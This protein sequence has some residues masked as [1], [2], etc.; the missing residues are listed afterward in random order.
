MA[1]RN[2]NPFSGFDRSNQQQKPVGL[3]KSLLT[4]D[5]K[6]QQ[7][8]EGWVVFDAKATAEAAAAKKDT[9]QLIGLPPS[10]AEEWRK[11]HSISVFGHDCPS[12][13]PDFKM[14]TMLPPFIQKKF[15]DRGFTAPTIIQA[16]SWPILFQNRDFVGIAKTGSGKTMA[17][18]VPAIAHI[19]VQ[20]QL[21]PGDGPIVV[22]LAPTRELAQQ[23]EEETKKILPTTMRCACIYGGSPK[24]PQIQ[25]L[26]DGVHI[27]VATP[28]RLIDMLEIKRTNLLRTTYVVLDEADRM[29][30]MGFE[31]QVRSIFG[32]VRPDRQTLMFSATWPKE[33]QS[34][35]A[36]FQKDFIRINV[37]STELLAN[38]DVT[39]EFIYT[40]E[41]GKYVELRKLMAKHRDT[42]VLVFCKTKKTADFLERQLRNVGFDIMAIH[43][44]KEQ[45]QREYILD[46]FRRE[47][48]L[49]VVA[50]DVAARGLDIKNLEVVINYDFPM[51]IDDYVHRIGRTGRAGA[52]GHSYTLISKKE[53]QITPPVL[54]QLLSIIQKAG[55]E[56][57]EFLSE[58]AN[59]RQQYSAV[60]RPRDSHPARGAPAMRYNHGNAPSFDPASGQRAN[61]LSGQQHLLAQP[62][63]AANHFGGGAQQ[64]GNRAYTRF[65]DSDDEDERPAKHHRA[66]Q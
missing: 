1:E 42:R 8:K 46:R 45:R 5:W 18:I 19:A 66:E 61:F 34:M 13:M 59:S 60:R 6:Q 64:E 26:R 30:D 25:L 31:P 3:G 27:L 53:D 63:A 37:G 11:T 28:G 54:R 15:A 21:R 62:G 50:T 41:D 49:T 39:Q 4:V 33:I 65:A 56:V 51:Q 40:P 20:P 29:L 14:L 35:A 7:Q 22:V 57:P 52:K 9:P 16:Q 12:P 23:I 36:S 58:W 44:D 32:Q 48:K 2:Y 47:S 24:G 38:P 10:E 43:G 55:Q 17:F